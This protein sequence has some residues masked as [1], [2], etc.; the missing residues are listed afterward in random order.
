MHAVCLPIESDIALG[1]I[2]ALQVVADSRGPWA[3]GPK[4]IRGPRRCVV[5]DQFV[6]PAG[7]SEALVDDRER[8]V[9]LSGGCAIIFSDLALVAFSFFFVFFP[10]SHL[11]LFSLEKRSF[12]FFLSFFL[13]FFA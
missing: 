12:S 1:P 9:E 10:P 5:P 7:P 3:A 11:F 8:H 13:S 6:G 2:L 4:Q